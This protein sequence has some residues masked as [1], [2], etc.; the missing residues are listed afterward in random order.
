MSGRASALILIVDDEPLN[1]DLLEQELEDLGYRTEPAYGGVEALER[2]AARHPDLI[3]LDV[4]MP[5]LD[6]ITVCRRLKNDPETQLIPIVIMTALDSPEDRIRGIEAGADDFLTKPVDDRELL[7]RIRT[8]LRTK[9]A[10]DH[11]V[12]ELAAAERD[13]ELSDEVLTKVLPESVAARLKAGEQSITDRF[14]D[15]TVLFTDIVGF[16]SMSREHSAEEVMSD[17]TKVFAAFDDLVTE[18][19]LEKIKTTGDGYM[20][21]GGATRPRP[22]HT[23]AVAR[24]ALAMQAASA[25]LNKSSALDLVMRYGIAVGPAV[26]AILGRDRLTFDIWG[27]PVNTASRMESHSLP[28]RIQVTERVYARLRTEF[29]FESRGEIEV[30]GMGPMNTYFLEGEAA[31]KRPGSA[32]PGE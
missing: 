12:D 16:T 28:G 18:C 24:L 13:R 32:S 2:V 4:M 30:K 27:E 25:E 31:A 1:V 26:G 14:D 23:A 6:G 5:D 11:T 8:A 21:V 10:V 22:D 3:L 19:G 17:L 9:A 29:A 20:V 15:I 7:A